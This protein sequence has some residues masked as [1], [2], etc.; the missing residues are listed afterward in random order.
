MINRGFLCIG[1]VACLCCSVQNCSAQIN[2]DQ[3]FKKFIFEKCWDAWASRIVKN[4]NTKGWYKNALYTKSIYEQIATAIAD[5]MTSQNEFAPERTRQGFVEFEVTPFNATYE[6]KHWNALVLY[7]CLYIAHRDKRMFGPILADEVGKSLKEKYE[8]IPGV[9]KQI[10]GAVAD[11]K[12]YSKGLEMPK[13]VL[14]LRAWNENQNKVM[15]PCDVNIGYEIDGYHLFDPSTK[16]ATFCISDAIVDI[17]NQATPTMVNIKIQGGEVVEYQT[18]YGVF[19]DMTSDMKL[20]N[21]RDGR[22]THRIQYG[23]LTKSAEAQNIHSLSNL[24]TC[25]IDSLITALSMSDLF[26]QAIKKV[27]SMQERH[28]Q[29]GSYDISLTLCK[30]IQ[31]MIDGIDDG[32]MSIG[33]GQGCSQKYRKLHEELTNA[34]ATTNA[35]MEYSRRQNRCM[36]N[37]IPNDAEFKTLLEREKKDAVTNIGHTTMMLAGQNVMMAIA[38]EFE[39]YGIQDVL[40]SDWL[41]R[42][43]YLY[44]R[45][46]KGENKSMQVPVCFQNNIKEI[47]NN[48]SMHDLILQNIRCEGKTQENVCFEIS[49]TDNAV[50]KE[51][52]EGVIRILPNVLCVIMPKAEGKPYDIKLDDT[53]EIEDTQGKKKYRLVS[54]VMRLPKHFVARI[55]LKDGFYIVDD[56]EPKFRCAVK[57]KE[58][59]N[60]YVSYMSHIP[61]FV[62]KRDTH[63]AIYERCD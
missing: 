60:Y 13:F 39:R 14:R 4:M 23:D 53:F 31:K 45:V 11:I 43:R 6:R 26:R 57:E 51:V 9:D 59:F 32:S 62:D 33:G 18:P 40:Q 7:N 58:Y 28:V 47:K 41:E 49:D 63:I 27:S 42:V 34:L 8:E 19:S 21:Q 56:N 29:I 5:I 61:D 36:H 15:I 16:S 24:H 17:K 50:D 10:D 1:A 54:T 37:N 46:Q 38:Y 55:K 35:V 30:Q 52:T 44:T 12:T 48:M 20:L 3:D 25:H 22:Q 2:T